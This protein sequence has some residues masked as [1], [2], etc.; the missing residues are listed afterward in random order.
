M[1]IRQ[2]IDELAKIL[3]ESP[4]AENLMVVCE[5]EAQGRFWLTEVELSHDEVILQ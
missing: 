5:N 3:D 1:T 2:L 4:G